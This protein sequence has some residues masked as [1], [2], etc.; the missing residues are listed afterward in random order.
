[1]VLFQQIAEL[2]V[3]AGSADADHS[4]GKTLAH[5]DALVTEVIYVGAVGFE[6]DMGCLRILSGHGRE[7]FDGEVPAELSD[8]DGEAQTETAFKD[9]CPCF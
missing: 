9:V 5:A 3:A 2:L 4:A 6:K 1:M 8:C 7:I